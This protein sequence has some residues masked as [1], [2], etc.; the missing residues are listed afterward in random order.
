MFKNLKT[1]DQSKDVCDNER[2]CKLALGN[3]MQ[4]VK[5]DWK[6]YDLDVQYLKIFRKIVGTGT[7]PTLKEAYVLVEMTPSQ[8]NHTN[9][10]IS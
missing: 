8:S 10:L 4:T 7:P 1:L 3:I 9:L 6:R 5:K 2:K